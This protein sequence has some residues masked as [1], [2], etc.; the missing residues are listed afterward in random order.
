MHCAALLVCVC[1]EGTT[2]IEQ[3]EIENLAERIAEYIAQHASAADAIDGI[4]QWWL[5]DKRL[6][7][8]R[9]R[10]EAALELLETR[11]VVVSSVHR[12]GHVIYAARPPDPPPRWS[13][14]PADDT[15]GGPAP[16]QARPMERS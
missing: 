2:T 5:P 1:T 4:M 9:E 15:H 7:K 11:G 6:V 3:Q 13:A 16:K 12:D 14:S 10:V 8:T